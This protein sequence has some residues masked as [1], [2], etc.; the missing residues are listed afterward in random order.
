MAISKNERN[1]RALL[2]G[3]AFIF[4]IICF[5][6]VYAVDSNTGM[7]T[8]QK[9]SVFKEV[10]QEVINQRLLAID[11]MQY[12]GG[13]RIKSGTYGDSKTGYSDAKIAYNNKSHSLFVSGHRLHGSI[14]E[15]PVP[16]LVNSNVL[17]ELPVS[18]DPIQ[19]FAKVLDRVNAVNTDGINRI[20]GMEYIDGELLIHTYLYYGGETPQTTLVA[21]DAGNL[22][23]TVLDGFF[24]FGGKAHG[25]LWISPIPLGWQK[26]FGGDYLSG[27]STAMPVSG[28]SSN[29]PSAFVFNSADI[30]NTQ[31]TFGA[32]ETTGVLDFSLVHTMADTD[33]GWLPFSVW[34]GD[35]EYN[36][37]GEKPPG[38]AFP[39]VYD[40][41][42]VGNNN[43]WT[44]GSS[45]YYGLIVPGTRTYAVFGNSSMH[46]SGG[47]Y[48]ITQKSGYHCGGP[49]PYD[50]DDQYNYYWFFDV[51]DL[52]KV[53]NGKKQP[54]E[55]K[56][57]SY[58]LFKT[59]FDTI[60]D[61]NVGSYKVF[62]SG[63]SYDAKNGII[64]FSLAKADKLQHKFEPTPVIMAYKIRIR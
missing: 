58:G 24:E 29:G 21:R 44:N 39:L 4:N 36:Y 41:N 12:I 45:A 23:S 20:G 7:R 33:A 35:M 64:Y 9:L 32:V 59:P 54:Y 63:G 49:C 48:K 10:W 50:P 14:G 19:D 60:S 51:N 17:S 31:K 62:I 3:L 6:T 57:Y 37:S 61:P 16:P 53:K 40:K 56:P 8:S 43:L 42:L 46:Q 34:G 11:D 26:H 5:S 25:I 1:S 2:T 47:G 55:V 28:R 52:V 18:G 22:R 30:I 15:F 13:F 38:D 27:S